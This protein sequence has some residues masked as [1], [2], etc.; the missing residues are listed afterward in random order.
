MKL[1]RAE[2]YYD[3]PKPLRKNKYPFIIC[4]IGLSVISFFLFFV[5]TIIQSILLAFKKFVGYAENGEDIYEWSVYNFKL[6]FR[7]LSDSNSEAGTSLLLSLKNTLLIYVFGNAVTFPLGC[8]I[9]YYLWKEM[10]GYT[11]YRVIFYLPGVISSVVMVIIY[12]NIIAPNGL[13]GYFSIQFTGHTV[14][15]FLSQNSTAIWFVL[16]YTTWMGFAGQYL[17]LTAAMLRIPTEVVEAAKLDGIKPL[18]EFFRICVPMI[19][20]TLYIILLQKITAILEADGP[21]LLLT[22]GLYDTSTLGFWSYKQVFL[23]HSY[24]YPAAVGIV[25]TLVIAPIAIAAKYFMS[26]VNKDVDY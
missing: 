8:F 7:E 15:P 10:K 26:K 2:N 21:I 11:F 23:G 5:N 18:C 20:P 9:S 17:L 25:M 4:M 14:A 16:L 1:F 6:I 19:W 22:G 3:F 13:I 24:E 12:R